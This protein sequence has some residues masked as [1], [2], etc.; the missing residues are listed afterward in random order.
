MDKKSILDEIF[1]NDPF[2]LL[3]IKPR[4]SHSRNEDERLISS[5]EEINSFFEKE[6]REP[7]ESQNMQERTLFARLAS[8]RKN[9]TKILA[10]KPY[11]RFGLLNLAEPKEYN[12]IDDLLQDD[13]FG[14]LGDDTAGLFDLKHVSYSD[15]RASADF[16]ARRKPCKDFD[17]YEPLLK[18]VQKDISLGKRKLVNFNQDNLRV[19]AFYVHNGVLFYLKEIN[20]TQKEHYKPDGT[21]VREDGRTRCIF[22]NGTESNMLKRS[23]E[24]ILYANGKVVT[25]NS[26]EVAA[27]LFNQITEKDQAFGYIYVLQSKSTDPAIKDLKD[28]YKIGYSIVEISDRLKNASKEPTYLMAEVKLVMS[29]KCYNMNPQ[30][31]E[32]LLHNFFGSACLNI[33]IFDEKGQRHTP[34]EWFIAPLNIIEEAIGLIVENKILNYTYSKIDGIIKK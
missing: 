24:K 13:S 32:M 11:D 18:A 1:S 14:L 26:D 22:E 20:I 6:Q 15:E 31:L 8:L 27:S 19:G 7:L 23:V 33:D 16:I 2:G 5:F 3:D 21:R 4:A 25:E 34:R 29:F 17:K 9:P 10:L 12:S 28:L 30:K